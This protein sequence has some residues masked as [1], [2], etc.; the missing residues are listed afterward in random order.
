MP[1]KSLVA[2]LEELR[3][4]RA[5]SRKELAAL[6][7]RGQGRPPKK[8][9][10]ADA[11]LS[12]RTA[13]ATWD[14]EAFAKRLG[15]TVEVVVH[16]DAVDEFRRALDANNLTDEWHD[17]IWSAFQQAKTSAIGGATKVRERPK[18]QRAG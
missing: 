17:T 10:T 12:G 16:E 13:L 11:A 15:A 2:R 8:R 9:Q 7:R 1:P 14:A 18:K 5:V 6:M 4:E 3:L